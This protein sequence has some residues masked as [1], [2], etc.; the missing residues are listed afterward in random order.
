MR[1]LLYTA[2]FGTLKV[3]YFAFHLFQI[4]DLLHLFE[5][6]LSIASNLSA[7]TDPISPIF[8]PFS[9]QGSDSAH[10]FRYLFG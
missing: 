2:Q 5:L 9:A 7:I 4:Y 6:I 10:L 8:Y 1:E 3:L